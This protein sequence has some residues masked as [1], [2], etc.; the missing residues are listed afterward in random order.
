[1]TDEVQGEPGSAVERVPLKVVPYYVEA[2]PIVEDA[3]P[4]SAAPKPAPVALPRRRTAA[5]G[6]LSLVVA[7]LTVAAL[8]V[9]IVVAS[10]GDFPLGTLLSYLAIGLSVVA[11]VVAIVA[12]VIG[13]GRRW[14]VAAVIV[15]ILAN[16]LVL[17]W[18]LTVVAG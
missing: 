16:P 9:A 1:V 17:R 15:A 13:R 3:V 4:E 2:E 8:V 10:G 18:L 7:V 6:I 5:L 11:A 12:L 14:A